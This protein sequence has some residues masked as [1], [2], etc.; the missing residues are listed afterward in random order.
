[1]QYPY[2][3]PKTV[4]TIG[5]GSDKTFILQLFQD[6]APFDLT[7]MTAIVASFP[8]PNNEW[9]TESVANG[10]VTVVGSPGAGRIQIACPGRDTL[11]MLPNPVPQQFQ[12]L[13]V[14]VTLSG[15]AQV[16]TLTIPSSIVGGAI[17]SVVLNEVV[18]SYTAQSTDTD[19]SVFTAL[20][21]LIAQATPPFPISGVV[22]G[23]PGTAAL[24]LT[25][26]IPA[27]GF[28]D[29]VSSNITK[30]ATTA[31][32]GSR[33]Q[34]VLRNVLNIVPQPYPLS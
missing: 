8:G 12:D 6:E 30:T 25:S 29:I 7:S 26:T 32:G 11:L 20:N 27:L 23:S 18:F 33:A 10:N 3:R 1:M 21:T 13:Q 5:V 2:D 14:I 19:L 28:T 22:S 17:Y 34:F 9:V 16:D 15:V 4:A 31:N 24:T